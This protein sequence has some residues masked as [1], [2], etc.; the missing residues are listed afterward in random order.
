MKSLIEV[1]LDRSAANF[2]SLTPLGFIERHDTSARND[3][4]RA[5]VHGGGV[6]AQSRHDRRPAGSA[7][8]DALP[9]RQHYTRR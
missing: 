6:R 1:H 9:A 5:S 7:I 3:S 2:A 4:G 8:L